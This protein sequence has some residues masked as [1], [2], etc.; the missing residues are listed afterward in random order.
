MRQYLYWK[1]YIVLCLFFAGMPLAYAEDTVSV[2]IPPLHTPPTAGKLPG[3]VI[4]H[5]LFTD[6]VRQ[7]A[8]FYRNVFGWHA[9]EFHGGGKTYTL[10]TYNRK[11]IAG[12][13]ELS[14]TDKNENQWVSY[15][16]VFDINGTA[17]YVAGNNGKVLISPRTFYQH[18]QV[19]VFADPEGA[20]F[21]VLNSFSGDPEDRMAQAGEWVWADL[22]SRQPQQAANF[23]Q[24]IGQYQVI[25]DT[26]STSGEDF[27]LRSDG[28]ARAGVGPLPFDDVLPNWLPYVRVRDVMDSVMQV[29]QF[30][31]NI[32]IQPTMEIFGGKLAIIADPSGAAFG[33]VQIDR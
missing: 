23:Y 9:E 32:L 29:T 26:Y 1:K 24:G 8:D 14:R 21:G 10:L 27:F 2:V 30:G 31:G 25:P 4:W 19:A 11:H 12:I 7:A 17:A 13:V 22:F 18:G 6:D 15:I 5:D 28:I 33:I 20:A 3:K 16:S